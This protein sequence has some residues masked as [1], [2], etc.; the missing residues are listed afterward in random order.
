MPLE[1]CYF[2]FNLNTLLTSI[3]QHFVLKHAHYFLAIELFYFYLK[4]G[5]PKR[6]GN[7]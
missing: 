5:L 7:T 6:D 4:N 3:L 2:I 1:Q